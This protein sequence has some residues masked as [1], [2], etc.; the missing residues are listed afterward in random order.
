MKHLSFFSL[1]ILDSKRINTMSP[2]ILV[3]ELVGEL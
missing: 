2:L 3:G 1:F